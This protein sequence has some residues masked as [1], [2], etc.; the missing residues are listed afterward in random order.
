MQCLQSLNFWWNNLGSNVLHSTCCS[1]L[2]CSLKEKKTPYFFLIVFFKCSSCLAS[3]VFHFTVNF[4]L[5]IHRE[6]WSTS[7][8]SKSLECSKSQKLLRLLLLTAHYDSAEGE[9]SLPAALWPCHCLLP[10]CFLNF[11]FVWV[12]LLAMIL[13]HKSAAPF[14][15]NDPWAVLFAG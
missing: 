7:V 10:L 1:V 13:L 9:P 5:W 6:G 8:T 3:F 11:R 2:P 15:W 12:V 14:S 4:S